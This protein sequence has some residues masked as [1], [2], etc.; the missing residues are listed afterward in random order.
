MEEWHPPLNVR[1]VVHQVSNL[2]YA[3]GMFGHLAGRNL[4]VFAVVSAGNNPIKTTSMQYAQS[5]SEKPTIFNEPLD[6]FCKPSVSSINVEIRE[7]DGDVVG[8][9]DIRL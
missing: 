3:S 8:D 5:E 1:V 7:N 6:L 9:A 2:R 4:K